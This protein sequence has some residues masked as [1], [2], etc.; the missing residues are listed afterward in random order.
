M[1]A[2]AGLFAVA[3]GLRRTPDDQRRA[4]AIESLLCR[5][6]ADLAGLNLPYLRRRLGAFE[7]QGLIRWDGS[8]LHASED[9]TPYVRGIAAA[10]DPYRQ[11]RA[12]AFSSAI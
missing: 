4:R 12:M 1:S 9:S 7:A 11:H 2:A 3:R 10:L 8:V 5:G 6:I